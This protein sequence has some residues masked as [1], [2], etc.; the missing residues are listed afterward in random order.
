MTECEKAGLRALGLEPQN[1][2][3]KPNECCNQGPGEREESRALQ[4]KKSLGAEKCSK[5]DRGARGEGR[6]TA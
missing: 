2:G 4:G 1:T 3:V 6:E 5:G